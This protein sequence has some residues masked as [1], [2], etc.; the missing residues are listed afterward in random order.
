M[1]GIRFIDIYA[2]KGIEYLIAIVFLVASVLICRYLYWP[3]GTGAGA[4]IAPES[5]A[6]FRVPEGLFYHQGHSWLRPEPGSIGIV[7]L[8][9]FAQ[10]LIGRVDSIELPG[11]GSRLAQGEKGWSL[12]VGSIPVSMLSPVDGEVVAVNQEVLRSPEFLRQDPYGKGWL[13]KVKSPRITADTKNLL[14]GK[15]ARAWM[16]NALEKL[17]PI[18]PENVGPVLADGGFPVEGIARALGGDKWADLARAHLLT[19]GE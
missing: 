8:D 10:K 6:R 18:G 5:A 17:H 1:E 11:V 3:R 4:R 16:E 14:S 12:V 7:G 13:L 9:D 19:E 2:T 15:L